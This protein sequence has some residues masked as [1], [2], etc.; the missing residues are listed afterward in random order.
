[1]SPLSPFASKS[2][3]GGSWPPQLLWQRRPCEFITLVAGERPNLLMVGN[4]D[5]L[6]DKKP[7]RYTEDNVTQW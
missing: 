3:G 2:E 4:N 1:M 7:Q 6:Y 5:E